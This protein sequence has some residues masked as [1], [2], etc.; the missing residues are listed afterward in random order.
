MCKKYK[1]NNMFFL[2]QNHRTQNEQK[3][4]RIWVRWRKEVIRCLTAD[5]NL[6]YGYLRYPKGILSIFYIVK[7]KT[8][9][10]GGFSDF[11]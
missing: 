9:I 5:N 6:Y 7:L 1:D 8:S 3:E 10:F 11:S 4:R 2:L